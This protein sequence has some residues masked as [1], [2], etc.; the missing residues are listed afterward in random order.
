LPSLSLRRDQIFTNQGEEELRHL[1]H[2]AIA[3][4]LARRGELETKSNR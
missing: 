2:A 1:C 4:L 3:A